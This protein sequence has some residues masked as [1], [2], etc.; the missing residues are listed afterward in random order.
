MMVLIVG[1]RLALTA[2][3]AARRAGL[4]LNGYQADNKKPAGAGCWWGHLKAY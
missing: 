4:A 3:D 2:L 1:W